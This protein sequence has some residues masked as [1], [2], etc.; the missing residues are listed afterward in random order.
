MLH[1]NETMLKYLNFPGGFAFS[2][3]DGKMMHLIKG[4][5]CEC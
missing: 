3:I 4:A 2:Q 1:V 5:G